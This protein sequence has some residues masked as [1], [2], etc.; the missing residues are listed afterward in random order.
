MSNREKLS[1][2]IK[3]VLFCGRQ[4]LPLRGHREDGE[5]I[6]EPIINDGNFRALLRFRIDA[7]DAVLKSHL[8]NAGSNATYVSPDIQNQVIDIFGEVFRRKIVA[9]PRQSKFFSVLSDETR[10]ASR[11]D[12]LTI[13]LRY[14]T[15]RN[16]KRVVV[17]NFLNFCEVADR[18]GH[19]LAKL[20]LDT[21]T[22]EGIDI[23]KMRGQ[24]YDFYSAE[25]TVLSGRGRG[26]IFA[27]E[28]QIPWNERSPR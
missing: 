7:G 6:D 24:G 18:T 15:C 14:V 12:Q 1:S 10:D 25:S 26:R 3:T 16:G 2:I 4:G 11:T 28:L 27:S 22:A 21:L 13:C 9:E 20:I 19:G 23:K 5:P 17:E 8:T